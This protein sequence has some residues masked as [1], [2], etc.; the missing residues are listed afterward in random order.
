MSGGRTDDEVLDFDLVKGWN[1]IT[2][3]EDGSNSY[4][5]HTVTAT[6]TTGSLHLIAAFE[7]QAPNP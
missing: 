1:L 6:A 3:P 5:T 7:S 4:F 2:T